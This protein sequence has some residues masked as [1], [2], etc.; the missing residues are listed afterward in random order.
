MIG[1]GPKRQ[2]PSLRSTE[3]LIPKKDDLDDIF[4]PENPAQHPKQGQR[5]KAPPAHA[6]A[7][8]PSS[9]R[10]RLILR[11]A[12]A[13]Q[14]RAQRQKEIPGAT[15]A[16]A[17]PAKQNAVGIGKQAYRQWRRPQGLKWGAAAAVAGVV[18]GTSVAYIANEYFTHDLDLE[19]MA[20]TDRAAAETDMAEASAT[21]LNG[22]SQANATATETSANSEAMEAEESS[23]PLPVPT[24]SDAEAG[25][26]EPNESANSEGGDEPTAP[27]Q[28]LPETQPS[29]T[30]PANA[31]TKVQDPP[32]AEQTVAAIDNT[33]QTAS[34]RSELVSERGETF[35]D[36]TLCPAMVKIPPGKFTMGSP[37]SEDGHQASESPPRLVTF[38]KPFAI[39][40]YEIT[41]GDWDA[42]VKDGD[43]KHRIKDEGWGRDKRPAINVSWEDITKQY[44]PWLEKKTGRAYRL[45]T[46]AEWEYAARALADG[47]AATSFSF[48]NRAEEICSYANGADATAK[49]QSGGGSG[50]DCRDGYATTAPI[51]S[52]KPNKFGV[53]DMHGNVWEWVEDCWSESYAE[54]AADGSARVTSDCGSRVVRGGSWNSDVPKLRSAARGWNQPSGRNRSIGFRVVREL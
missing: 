32:A 19:M 1:L 28:T 24:I 9:V 27:S 26:D 13:R 39:G 5:A 49:E 48:G 43:C 23:Q 15:T 52:F 44:L 2:A 16:P 14:A 38:T 47:D 36:C 30:D 50:A 31:A 46:E 7:D 41:I 4:A 53:Y 40:Q 8:V 42:C 34:A 45:P 21:S 37:E 54:A 17:G 12:L 18:F 3:R 51:G 20:A 33:D 25:A 35:R 10:T 29:T 11:R 6:P 22:I